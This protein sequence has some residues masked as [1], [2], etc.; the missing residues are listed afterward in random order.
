MHV[1]Q[2]DSLVISCQIIFHD[3]VAANSTFHFDLESRLS[4]YQG[5]LYFVC[6]NQITWVCVCA[7][8]WLQVCVAVL[9][10]LSEVEV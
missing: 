2:T 5:F 8:G 1:N 9:S 7:Y 3:D 10:L 6:R 4:L